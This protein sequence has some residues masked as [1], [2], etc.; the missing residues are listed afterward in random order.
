MSHASRRTASIG[1]GVSYAQRYN[2]DLF[3]TDQRD[4]DDDWDEVEWEEFR[5]RLP[6]ANHTILDANHTGSRDVSRS[7][8]QT[9]PARHSMSGSSSDH[10]TQGTTLPTPNRDEPPPFDAELPST[11][12]E[13][14]PSLIALRSRPTRRGS[15]DGTQFQR[16]PLYETYHQPDEHLPPIPPYS[17]LPASPAVLSAASSTPVSPTPSIHEGQ[18][19]HSAQSLED[20]RTTLQS[21]LR[22]QQLYRS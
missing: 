11:S 12:S 20:F 2:H 10:H 16:T 4:F 22:H 3:N 13:L 8:S 9:R 18:S 7:N 21:S 15:V 1:P 17:P 5:G 19:G 14:V 6:R